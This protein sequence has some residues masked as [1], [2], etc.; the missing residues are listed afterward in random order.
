MRKSIMITVVGIMLL[1]GGCGQ[2][3]EVI[4]NEISS[5]VEETS[6]VTFTDDLGREVTVPINP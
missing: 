2:T 4:D 6:K 3:K 5:T 1:F